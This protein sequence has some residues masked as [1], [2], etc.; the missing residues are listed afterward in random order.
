MYGTNILFQGGSA[1]EIGIDAHT[2]VTFRRGNKAD[3]CQQ[4]VNLELLNPETGDQ[5]SVGTGIVTKVVVTSL[6]NLLFELSER[7]HAVEAGLV[8]GPLGLRSFLEKVYGGPLDDAT[9]FSALFISR[10]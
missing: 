6:S 10:G 8:E 5:T 3:L 4:L 1:S 9:V 2:F 7:N